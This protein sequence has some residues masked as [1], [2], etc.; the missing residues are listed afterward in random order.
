MPEPAAGKNISDAELMVRTGLGDRGA[1]AELVRR[2]QRPLLNFFRRVGARMDEAEDLVQETFL[3]VYAYRERYRPSGKFSSFLYVLA[4]H[5]WAD[6][7]RKGARGPKA[8]MEALAGS[9]V[10][11]GHSRTDARLDVQE[12][13]G[14]LSEKLRMV[15]VLSIY[16]GLKQEEIAEAL[17]IPVGTV[18]SRMHLALKRMK[19]LLDVGGEG[20][21]H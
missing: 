10:P 9:A 15:L 19:E 3:R 5:A 21:G 20:Q 12:A 14:S 18:K 4:R 1:F 2:Y 7:A 11:G 8:D 16:Q 6:F 13:L 17:G